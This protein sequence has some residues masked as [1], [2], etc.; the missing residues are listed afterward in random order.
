MSDILIA[1][2]DNFFFIPYPG[3]DG[4]GFETVTKESHFTW[5]SAQRL[6]RD[7]ALQFTGPGEEVVT[8]QGHVY[9]LLFGGTQT[10]DDLRDDGRAGAPL[11]LVAFS[12]ADDLSAMTGTKVG[13]FAI[14]R[15]R[16]ESTKVSGVGVPHQIDF[17]LELVAYGDDLASDGDLLDAVV[18]DAAAAATAS[19]GA[20]ASAVTTLLAGGGSSTLLDWG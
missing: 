4:L 16:K 3:E 1:L 19:V 13:R 18:P 7:P 6:S 10:L 2:G 12:S 20:A 11:D 14:R 17:V 15:L 8:L 5:A 9:P